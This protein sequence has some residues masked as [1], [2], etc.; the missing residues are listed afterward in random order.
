MNFTTLEAEMGHGHIVA[1]EPQEL[2][3]TGSGLLTIFP[4]SDLV[5]PRPMGVARGEFTVPDD[6]NAPLPGG[7]L[8]SFEGR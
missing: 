5:A 6:F 8:R 2:P 7:M 4:T 1:K 3:E